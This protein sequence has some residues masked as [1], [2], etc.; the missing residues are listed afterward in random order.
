MD[1]CRNRNLDFEASDEKRAS[2]QP[3][4]SAIMTLSTAP[5]RFSRLLVLYASQTGNAEW[6]ARHIREEAELRRGYPAAVASCD[7]F[8]AGK[9]KPDFDACFGDAA[10]PTLLVLVASTTGD[11]D[12]PDNATKFYRFLKRDPKRTA[13]KDKEYLLLGLGDTNYDVF[14]GGAKRLD[15]ELV[16]LGMKCLGERGW[17]DDAT[18]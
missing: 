1:F 2:P 13:L 4:T 10:D 9:S 14:C 5:P 7:E 18:G 3:Q 8:A 6:I 15:R 12:V 16:K 11:G 17:A